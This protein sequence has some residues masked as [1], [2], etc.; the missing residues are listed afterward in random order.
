[1]PRSTDPLRSPKALAEYLKV[2]RAN[3]VVQ[4]ELVGK[5]RLSLLP[6]E[7]ATAGGVMDDAQIAVAIKQQ[8]AAAGWPVEQ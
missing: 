3:G 8:M 5:L 2:L 7:R 1:M 6:E 4:A